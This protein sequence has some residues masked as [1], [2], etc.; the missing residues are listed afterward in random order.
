MDLFGQALRLC[1]V[2]LGAGGLAACEPR[3]P[4]KDAFRRTGQVIALSGGDG[5]AANACFSC[6][7]LKGEGDGEASPR[8]AGLDAAW[9]H[10]QLDDYASGR[11]PDPVM[12]P[13][14]R[15]LT[16]EDRR[17]VSAWHAALP[18]PP[19]AASS[20]SPVGAKLYHQGDARRG[21]QPCEVCHGEQ[22]E[23]GGA[24]N[25][26][27]AGQP[28][29]YIAE[30]LDRWAN[31]RRRNDPR[32]VMLHISRRLTPAEIEAVAAYATAPASRPLQA[33]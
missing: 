31:A 14:A 33:P 15:H 7:G 21:L 10:R 32:D 8:L 2:G 30:Q 26:P 3:D 28:P 1:I 18:T 17:A 6:H 29:A 9:M 24:A 27:L 25:P 23:G 5:G 13:I 22:G 11:R 20:I 19:S 12:G 4:P 16:A